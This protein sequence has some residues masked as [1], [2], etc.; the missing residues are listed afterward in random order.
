M[1]KRTRDLKQVALECASRVVVKGD[2]RQVLKNAELFEAW[3]T[4]DTTEVAVLIRERFD[5]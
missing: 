5:S 3:L 4:G 2:V 1:D